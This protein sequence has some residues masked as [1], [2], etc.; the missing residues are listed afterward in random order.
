MSHAHAKHS[1]G[2]VLSFQPLPTPCEGQN[3]SVATTR[4]HLLFSI[5]SAVA[6]G[7]RELRVACLLSSRRRAVVVVNA[8][9]DKVTASTRTHE[10]TLTSTQRLSCSN[11]PTGRLTWQPDGGGAKPENQI[12]HDDWEIICTVFYGICLCLKKY[13]K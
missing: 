12:S 7:N 4:S 1:I 3:I 2:G 10:Q 8:R 6:W 13:E 5:Y 9:Q 11:L